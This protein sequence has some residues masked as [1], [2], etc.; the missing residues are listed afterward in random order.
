MSARRPGLF[1]S[2]KTRSRNGLKLQGIANATTASHSKG[3]IF[4]R[5]IVSQTFTSHIAGLIVTHTWPGTKTN[6]EAILHP[7]LCLARRAQAAHAEPFLDRPA[8]H[9]AEVLGDSGHALALVLAVAELCK[10]RALVCGGREPPVAIIRARAFTDMSA[11]TEA[12]R[13]MQ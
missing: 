9:P 13:Y 3:E 8:G 10:E 4:G 5:P 12:C 7:C 1:F 6:S 11:G 2:L